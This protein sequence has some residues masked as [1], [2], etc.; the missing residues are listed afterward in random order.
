MGNLLKVL[1]CKEQDQT[2]GQPFLDFEN[3]QPVPIEL[4]VH[5]KVAVVLSHSPHILTELQNYKG[6]AESI[7][8]SISNPS[9]Q[10][11]QCEAWESIIPLVKQQKQ[12]YLFSKQLKESE[13][14]LLG[15]LTSNETTTQQHLEQKQALAK[16]FAEILQFTIKF[17]DAKM[18][19][20][21]LQNDLSYFR[22]TVQRRGRTETTVDFT[23]ASCISTEEANEMSLFYAEHTPMLK[24]LTEAAISFVEQNP[25]KLE[26][27]KRTNEVLS[28]MAQI[29]KVMLE[30]P[31]DERIQIKTD[32]IWF[33]VEVLV[34]LIILYDHVH[35]AGVFS[36]A[37]KID[38][39]GCIRVI[40]D[41]VQEL[42]GGNKLNSFLN[43]IRY[44]TKHYSDENTPKNIS[45]MLET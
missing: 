10:K 35:N 45:K 37:S 43:A 20:P 40:K 39:K 33:C 16:Q 2:I 42:S 9:C 21:D 29:C 23:L 5:E 17:D 11:V 6:A 36:K 15:A 44:T 25:S 30:N 34:G 24:A 13:K 8:K 27:E 3:A 41:R 31:N 19:K 14:L 32:S 1:Q 38:V 12:F 18:N 22:R 4:E 7:K 26:V 28:T